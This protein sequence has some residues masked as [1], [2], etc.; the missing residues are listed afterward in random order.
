MKQWATHLQL[1]ED[2]ED[3]IVAVESNR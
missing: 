1:D 3:L 2:L